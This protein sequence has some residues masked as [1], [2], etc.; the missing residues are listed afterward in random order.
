MIELFTEINWIDS[1][2][3]A[4]FGLILP[5]IITLT[6]NFIR[7]NKQIDVM[8]KWYSFN[9]TD[10]DGQT[11]IAK[12]EWIFEKSLLS[13]KFKARGTSQI[14]SKVKYEAD[15]FFQMNIYMSMVKV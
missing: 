11:Q 14:D 6:I 1:F 4:I 15:F 12:Y 2:L 8:G 7:R 3:G 5:A 13:G 10:K 9:I